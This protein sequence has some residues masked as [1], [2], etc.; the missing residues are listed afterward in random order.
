[1]AHVIG[2]RLAM[3]SQY[4]P[5]VANI[6]ALLEEFKCGAVSLGP[7]DQ[8]DLA[9]GFDGSAVDCAVSIRP[10]SH[11]SSSEKRH[12]KTQM[13]TNMQKPETYTDAR[14]CTH[15]DAP[16]PRQLLA[17]VPTQKR[18][19][20]M[21]VCRI[22]NVSYMLSIIIQGFHNAACFVQSYFRLSRIP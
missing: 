4:P 21:F 5:K 10:Y 8:K 17:G 14:A 18:N 20:S 13:H 9:F 15:T 16:P 2:Q 3:G 22:N 6:N 12:N 7:G 11:P 19:C 1:M